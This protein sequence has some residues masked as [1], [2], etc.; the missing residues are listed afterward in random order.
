[1]RHARRHRLAAPALSFA[2]ATLA[3]CSAPPRPLP[4]PDLS[5]VTESPALAITALGDA[6]G[7]A[8][9]L[10]FDDTR[11][12]QLDRLG[13]LGVHLVR[14]DF[15]WP[16]LEPSAGTFD[17]SAED[18]AVDDSRARGLVTIG[19]LAYDTAWASPDGDVYSPPD[20]QKFAAFVEATARHFAGRVDQWE[21]W[22]EPNVGY[23]FWKP[24]ED[25]FAYARLL[26]AAYPAVKRGNPQA[27]VLL[28]G[29]FYHNEGIVTDAVSFLEDAF[30]ADPRLGRWFDVLALHPY[31]HY[32]PQAAPEAN[33]GREQPVG[34]MLARLRALLAYYGAPRPIW[35]TE[36]GWPVYGTVDEAQQAR[37]SVRAAVEAMAAGAERVCLYTL[38]DGPNPT[39]FPPE[40]AFGLYH[41]DG[42]LKPAARALQTLLSID[43]ALKLSADQSGGGLRH[44]V[45]QSAATRLHVLFADD[46]AMHALPP[47]PGA[48]KL[49]GLDGAAVM[50]T[51]VGADPIFGVTKLN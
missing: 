32:P 36:L 51:T 23:R 48:P 15:L 22:N 1:M 9:Q 28:G 34:L 25:G 35:V 42:T 12:A 37:F 18:A 4:P 39:A 8:N 43:P 16:S 44:Y 38:D 27:T 31:A 17:F 40:D 20:P 46:G 41:H 26:A 2:L 24:R 33:D 11:T 7:I 14:R 21:I 10:A 3:A 5:T 50:T 30:T 13:A 19:I 29:L 49:I 47:L 6:I 45:W